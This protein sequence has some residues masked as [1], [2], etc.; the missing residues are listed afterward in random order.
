MAITDYT[1]TDANI[2]S[3]VADHEWLLGQLKNDHAAETRNTR[4][5][6]TATASG[7][8]VTFSFAAAATFVMCIAPPPAAS[9]AAF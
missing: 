2:G 6:T 8:A 5:V 3:V 7:V 9:P 1:L 4:R